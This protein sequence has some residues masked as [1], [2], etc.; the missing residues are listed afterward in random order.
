MRRRI[1]YRV[2]SCTPNGVVTHLEARLLK[3][4]VNQE[5]HPIRCAASCKQ[6]YMKGARLGDLCAETGHFG[7]AKKIWGFTE[8]LIDVKDCEDYRYEWFDDKWVSI[9]DVLSETECELLSRRRSD[10]WTALGFPEESWWDEKTERYH[11]LRFGTFYWDL[12]EDKFGYN[13]MKGL[14]EYEKEMRGYE[15]EQETE[16][17]FHEGQVDNLPACSQDFM[18]YWHGSPVRE[19]FSWIDDPNQRW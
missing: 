19:D 12:W 17:I 2:C 8:Y 1:P 11:S 5:I 15:A 13:P 7:W 3:D 9:G 4:L 14:I 6:K 18:E 16:T 10:L